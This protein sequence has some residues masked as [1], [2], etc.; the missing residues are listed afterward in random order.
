[1]TLKEFKEKAKLKNTE[2]AWMFKAERHTIARWLKDESQL[3]LWV[4][5]YLE[6]L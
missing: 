3:P 5:I 6:W 2:L 1:M 4:K